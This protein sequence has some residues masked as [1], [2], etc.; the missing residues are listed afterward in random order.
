MIGVNFRPQYLISYQFIHQSL[1]G[2]NSFELGGI[3]SFSEFEVMSREIIP[4]FMCISLGA[5][6]Y[7]S[8]TDGVKVSI[9]ITSYTYAPEAH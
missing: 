9:G 1:L 8:V 4:G 6:S 2:C 5:S 3:Y 7:S